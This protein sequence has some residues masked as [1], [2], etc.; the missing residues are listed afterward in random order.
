MNAREL[1]TRLLALDSCALSDALDQ[2]KLPPAVVGLI[3]QTVHARVGGRVITVK[4]AAGVPPP[5]SP[6][7]H[8]CTAAIESASPGDVIVV[9]QLTGIEAAGWGGILSNAAKVRGVSAAIIEGPARD[10]DEA[11]ELGF[12]VFSRSATCRTAR[13]RIHEA[14]T[15]VPIQVGGVELSSGDYVLADRSGAVF[16]KAGNLGRVLDAAEAVACRESA[17]TRAVRN[18]EP[19][20]QVMGA[21]YEDMLKPAR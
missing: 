2:L 5:G 10:I 15:G 14:A 3:P 19:V 4:L 17:M 7:R 11:A 13:G 9:E 18:G 21:R 8:L 16:I 1:R 12:P 6:T 20:S